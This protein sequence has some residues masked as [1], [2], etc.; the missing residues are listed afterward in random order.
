MA[1]EDALVLAEAF[2]RLGLNEE[3]WKRFEQVR[4]E[5]VSWIVSTSWSIGK[6]CHMRNPLLRA[7]RNVA[8]KKTP[9]S[10]TRKQLQRLYNIEP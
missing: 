6:V 2:E 5:K 1:V 9:A 7:L 4:R 10:V 3:A 8:L